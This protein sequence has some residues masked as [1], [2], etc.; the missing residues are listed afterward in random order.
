LVLQSLLFGGTQSSE[1]SL[2]SLDLR[3]WV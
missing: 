1:R 2:D 3:D